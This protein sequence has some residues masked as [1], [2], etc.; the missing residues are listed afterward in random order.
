MKHSPPHERRRLDAW[1]AVR[2]HL[3]LWLLLALAITV[4]GSDCLLP[5]FLFPGGNRLLAGGLAAL[6]GLLGWGGRPGGARGARWGKEAAS[7]ASA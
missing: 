5:G 3:S 6:P 2:L 7:G 4:L 1:F